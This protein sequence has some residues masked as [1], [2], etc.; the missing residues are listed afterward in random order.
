M[1]KD[2]DFQEEKNMICDQT[3]YHVF[4]KIIIRRMQRNKELKLKDACNIC[5]AV[6][7]SRNQLVEMRR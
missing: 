3:V 2:L 4:E 7:S 6:V 5:R 1:D